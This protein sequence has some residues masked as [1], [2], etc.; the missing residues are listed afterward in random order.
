MKKLFYI[1][2]VFALLLITNSCTDWDT[3]NDEYYHVT[4]VNQSNDT[5][6]THVQCR[7]DITEPYFEDLANYNVNIILPSESFKYPIRKES[8]FY[9]DK[10]SL[11]VLKKSTCEKYTIDEVREQKIMDYGVVYSYYDLEKMKFVITY[12][13]QEGQE[14]EE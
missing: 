7:V 14:E 13:G 12:T 8:D 1:V 4:V 5:I 9:G 3:E 2:T 11:I 10:F 6:F